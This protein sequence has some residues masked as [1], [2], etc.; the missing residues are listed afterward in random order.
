MQTYLTAIDGSENGLKPRKSQAHELAHSNRISGW[1]DFPIID[2]K[3]LRLHV[4]KQH[5]AIFYPIFKVLSYLSSIFVL[6]WNLSLSETL[7]H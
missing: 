6:A 4:I 2:E 3:S 7:A 5:N 1:P